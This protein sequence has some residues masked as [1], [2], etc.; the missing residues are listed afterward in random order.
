MEIF[1]DFVII[2]EWLASNGQTWDQYHQHLESRTVLD[3]LELLLALMAM[4]FHLNLLHGDGMWSTRKDGSQNSDPTLAWIGDGFIFCDWA[5]QVGDSDSDSDLIVFHGRCKAICDR[6]AS[7]PMR[8]LSQH[9]GSNND[10]SL[11][12]LYDEK[13][14][15]K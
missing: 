5:G 1:P 8:R 9:D 10:N 12:N 2:R 4:S 3:G 6:A 14:A 13:E 11:S 7:G 15:P